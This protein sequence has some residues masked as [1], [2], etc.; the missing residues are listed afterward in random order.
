M[1]QTYYFVAVEGASKVIFRKPDGSFAFVAV[2]EPWENG[3]M[4]RAGLAVDAKR[5]LGVP[6]TALVTVLTV[7]P[8]GVP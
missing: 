8:G 3:L 5:L 6:A 1:R 7:L 2:R 4:R